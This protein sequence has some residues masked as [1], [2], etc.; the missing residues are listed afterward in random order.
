[1]LRSGGSRWIRSLLQSAS[2]LYP[3]R[4]L[5]VQLLSVN[6]RG[7]VRI[8]ARRVPA[9]DEGPVS[10]RRSSAGKTA[11]VKHRIDHGDITDCRLDVVHG[12]VLL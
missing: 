10:V 3:R 8:D 4:H 5:N 12:Q 6:R 1:M 7:A 11:P 2:R 9:S